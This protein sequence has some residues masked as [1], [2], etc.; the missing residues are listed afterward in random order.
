MNVDND[1]KVWGC[2][3]I[4]IAPLVVIG[5]EVLFRVFYIFVVC[6][7]AFCGARLAVARFLRLTTRI[8]DCFV[9]Y[10]GVCVFLALYLF[11]Y[12]FCAESACSAVLLSERMYS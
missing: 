5:G 4:A 9:D 1:V 6:C 2:V 3:G 8:C 12:L 11:V 7:W 10:L